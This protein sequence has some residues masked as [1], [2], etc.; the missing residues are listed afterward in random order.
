MLMGGVGIVTQNVNI[1]IVLADLIPGTLKTYNGFILSGSLENSNIEFN[2]AIA[3]VLTK[4]GGGFSSAG[5]L[6]VYGPQLAIYHTYNQAVKNELNVGAEACIINSTDVRFGRNNNATG[7]SPNYW[8]NGGIDPTI[9]SNYYQW[10]ASESQCNSYL[11]NQIPFIVDRGDILRVEGTKNVPL[12]GIVGNQSINF[13]EDFLV[14]SIQNYYYSSSAELN[15]LLTEPFN[16]YPGPQVYND[17]TGDVVANNTT[18][19]WPNSE[20]PGLFDFFDGPDVG[21][22][23]VDFPLDDAGIQTIEGG[24][25]LTYRVKEFPGNQEYSMT[26]CYVSR[27]GRQETTSPTGTPV[28]YPNYKAGMTFT[29]PIIGSGNSGGTRDLVI[30]ILP[31]NLPYQMIGGVITP[32]TAS[33]NNFALTVNDVCDANNGKPAVSYPAGYFA[34]QYPTFIETDRNPTDVITGLE[35][36]AEI[37]R[38]TIRRQIENETSVMGYNI[39]PATLRVREGT[40]IITGELQTTP[41]P[42]TSVSYVST[43]A[44][45][46]QASTII[47]VGDT[48]VTTSGAGVAGQIEL[49]KNSNNGTVASKGVRLIQQNSGRYIIGDTIT[50][51]STAPGVGGGGGSVIITLTAENLVTIPVSILGGANAQTGQGFLIPNDLSEV[52]NDNALDIINQLRS[53][54]AFPTDVETDTR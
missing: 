52:Q 30:E 10:A 14:T 47:T 42:Y 11:Q 37:T 5:L 36:G 50:I 25:Q 13:Q 28:Y 31:G 9:P 18:I 17:A 45:L 29:F 20:T 48:G 23:T 41:Y 12:S 22:T 19:Y 40:P 6:N 15:T 51:L 35:L 27:G 24:A 7:S 44:G 26:Q 1:N 34:V 43:I 8:V 16:T 32:N 54:N 49:V 3:G 21:S 33:E 53:K 2:Q 4:G 38:F 46:N 39:S